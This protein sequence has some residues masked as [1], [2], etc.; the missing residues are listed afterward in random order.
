[1]AFLIFIF[2]FIEVPLLIIILDA[3]YTKLKKIS[4]KIK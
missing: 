1:M 2:I 3:I 4:E